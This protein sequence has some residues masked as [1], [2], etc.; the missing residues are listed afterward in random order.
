MSD[1]FLDIRNHP[2]V[3]DFLQDGVSYAEG[4]EKE[5]A[6]KLIQVYED[7]GKLSTSTLADA[8]RK[9]GKAIWPA[10]QAVRRWML[11]EAIDQEWSQISA[12]VRPST[13]HLLNRLRKV[14]EAK[15]LDELLENPD[16]DLA[17]KDEEREEIKRIRDHI[18]LDAWNKKRE[19][20]KMYIEEAQAE[21]R[22][23]LRRFDMLRDLASS[24]PPV[25]AEEI[26]HKLEQYEDRVLFQGLTLSMEVLDD[27]IRYYTDQKEITPF[28]E[29][30]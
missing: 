2:R 3:I 27:E 13:S 23:Y 7:G 21:L 25:F 24:L 11:Q 12:A 14:T 10:R 16:A 8:A 18:F 19:H 9:L 26:T 4:P 30:G 15:H 17:L 29:A 28:D 20:L 22:G 6:A 1:L 5:A